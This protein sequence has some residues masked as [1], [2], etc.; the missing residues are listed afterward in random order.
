MRHNRHVTLLRESPSGETA[1]SFDLTSDETFVLAK[2]TTPGYDIVAAVVYYEPEPRPLSVQEADKVRTYKDHTKERVA[3]VWPW[4]MERADDGSLRIPFF[5]T[6]L[7]AGIYY[8]QL[9]VRGEVQS[10]PYT[11]PSEDLDIEGPDVIPATGLILTASKEAEAIAAGLGA[12][13]SQELGVG[14]SLDLIGTGAEP[15]SEITITEGSEPPPLGFKRQNVLLR[16]NLPHVTASQRLKAGEGEDAEEGGEG[17]TI[18]D[19]PLSEPSP[20]VLCLANAPGLPPVVAA[21]LV[22]ATMPSQATPPEGFEIIGGNLVELLARSKGLADVVGSMN[23]PSAEDA[24]EGEEGLKSVGVTIA[25]VPFDPPCVFLAV[26]RQ[27]EEE[28]A[29]ALA[30]GFGDG[31]GADNLLLDAA[32]GFEVTEVSETKARLDGARIGLPKAPTAIPEGYESKNIEVKFG[33]V[34]KY[35]E[36]LRGKLLLTY[37]KKAEAVGK[38]SDA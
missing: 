14:G 6:V 38:V 16:M 3:V 26:K 27:T 7:K 21:T 11:A 8:T 4:E 24:A 13:P 30:K 12:L 31:R 2:C 20:F 23:A 33:G 10:I 25:G 32:L 37:T 29:V 17:S 1:P 15:F 35:E 22:S 36:L 19:V 28:A 5:F 34:G 9:L 18:P